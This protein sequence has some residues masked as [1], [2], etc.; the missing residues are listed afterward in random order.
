MKKKIQD[1]R[2]LEKLEKFY[3]ANQ[4]CGQKEIDARMNNLNDQ[5]FAL[6][7]FVTVI[8]T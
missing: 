5:L 2:E 7:N 4:A 1:I 8:I 3:M 6:L